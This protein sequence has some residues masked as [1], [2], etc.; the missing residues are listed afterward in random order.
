M[1]TIV[2]KINLKPGMKQAFIEATRGLIAG[3]RSEAGNISYDL[4]EE[5]GG[6]DVMCFIEN[7]RDAAAIEAHNNSPHFKEWIRIKTELVETGEVVKYIK[8]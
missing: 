3:S 1:I 2:A 7:W 5:A 6:A 4:Y 8:L